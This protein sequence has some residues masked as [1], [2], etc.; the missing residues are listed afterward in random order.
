MQPVS[1]LMSSGSTL[2]NM[3][4]RSWL[5]PSLRYGSVSTT[6]LARRVAAIALASTPTKSMVATTGERNSGSATNGTAYA[7]SS[8]Q[9]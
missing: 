5:R 7:D 8:A 9:A 4:I 3:P 1:W 6:P 2:G